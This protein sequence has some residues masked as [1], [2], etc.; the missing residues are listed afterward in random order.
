MAV[1]DVH[2]AHKSGF[3]IHNIKSQLHANILEPQ[4]HAKSVGSIPDD[5]ELYGSAPKIL[6]RE[7]LSLNEKAG[8]QNA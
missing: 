4:Q 1:F 7:E 6:H 2:N 3:A 5:E 8:S